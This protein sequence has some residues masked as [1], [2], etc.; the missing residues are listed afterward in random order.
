MDLN[1]IGVGIIVL[2]LFVKI[3][4]STDCPVQGGEISLEW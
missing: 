3:M 4:L 2:A 1:L